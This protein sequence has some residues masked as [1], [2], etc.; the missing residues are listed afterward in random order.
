MSDASGYE[1]LDAALVARR[2]E[3]RAVRVNRVG[4]DADDVGADA[5][6]VLVAVAEGRQLR[7]ADEREVE[8]V[9][10]QHD[11]LALV[12]ESFDVLVELLDVLRGRHVEVRC[13]LSHFCFCHDALMIPPLMS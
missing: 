3:P 5:E 4:R 11:P 6:E 10:E 9:E 13:R 12:V 2:L 7:R 8:R 1:A